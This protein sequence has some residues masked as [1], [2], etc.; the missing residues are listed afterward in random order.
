[1]N[2]VQQ[3]YDDFGTVGHQLII[4]ESKD[5]TLE[6]GASAGRGH[7][8]GVIS[9]YGDSEKCQAAHLHASMRPGRPLCVRMFF[10]I[11]I[12]QDHALW[13]AAHP[14]YNLMPVWKKAKCIKFATCARPKS[15]SPNQSS[16]QTCHRD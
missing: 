5:Y 7:R 14:D 4:C 9:C 1:L 10:R 2:F 12:F 8:S 15:L 13:R 16:L 11:S 3:G 6:K